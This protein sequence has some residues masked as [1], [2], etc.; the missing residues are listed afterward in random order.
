MIADEPLADLDP[1]HQLDTMALLSAQALSG[2]LV[3]VILHD[4][5]LAS[6]WCD[7]LLLLSEGRI[8]ADG[9]PR[10]CPER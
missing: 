9:A 5:A 7:R 4:L 1:R 2:R 6:A 8:I 3:V 10:R